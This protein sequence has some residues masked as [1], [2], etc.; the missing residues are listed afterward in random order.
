MQSPT[1]SITSHSPGDGND[2]STPAVSSGPNLTWSRTVVHESGGYRFTTTVTNL[3]EVI[4]NITGAVPIATPVQPIANSGNGTGTATLFNP[5]TGAPAPETLV[6][7]P[8]TEL[9]SKFYV[10]FRG[11][12][13]GIFYDWHTEVA[14]LVVGVPF[15]CYHLYP[16]WPL[17][18]HAYT[19]AYHGRLPGRHIRVVTETTNGE[20]MVVDLSD[21]DESEAE[22]ASSQ[23]MPESQADD[24][25]D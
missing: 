5:P 6:Q 12:R 3:V 16:S 22:E 4:G 23:L 14:A 2:A 20:S 18:H 1:A 24:L 7:Q 17:A 9:H 8:G 13:V 25:Q 10:V 15:N 19:E 21:E 11:T